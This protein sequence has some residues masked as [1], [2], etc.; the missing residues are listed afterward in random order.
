MAVFVASKATDMSRLPELAISS[1]HDPSRTVDLHGSNPDVQLTLTQGATALVVRGDIRFDPLIAIF[2]LNGS[3]YGPVNYLQVQAHGSE[4]YRFSDFHMESRELQGY[5][6]ANQT[7]AAVRIILAGNDTITG[8]AFS[9]RLS[10]YAGDDVIR[11]G[12]GADLINGGDGR[13]L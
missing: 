6:E 2:D 1:S 8:S 9:D 5:I 7:W 11:G 4:A 10:G 12:S 3:I 13:T